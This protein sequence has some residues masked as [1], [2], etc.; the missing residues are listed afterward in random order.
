LEELGMVIFFR[1][2][3]NDAFCSLHMIL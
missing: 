2:R 1:L 3:Q